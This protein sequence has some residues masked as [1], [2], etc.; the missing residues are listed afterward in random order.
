VD[1]EASSFPPSLVFSF[2]HVIRA[3]ARMSPIN[4]S[5]LV[6]IVGGPLG[7][8]RPL[9]SL[10]YSLN[11]LCVLCFSFSSAHNESLVPSLWERVQA[12]FGAIPP[13][14]CWEGDSPLSAPDVCFFAN[15][16]Y[17]GGGIIILGNC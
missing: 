6:S 13:P 8:R 10:E 12:F 14:S 4:V 1:V 5:L 3:K 9:S 7:L 16:C 17:E 15:A 2:L 11:S